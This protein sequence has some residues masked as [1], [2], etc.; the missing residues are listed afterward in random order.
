MI[1]KLQMSK[2]EFAVQ[3]WGLRGNLPVP[4]NETL[5][6]GGNTNCVTVTIANQHLFIFDAGSGI[7][8]LAEYLTENQSNNITASIF[9]SHPH[10]DHINALPHFDPFYAKGNR[11]TIYGA[12]DDDTS[13]EKLMFGQMDNPHYP[14]TMKEMS[15]ELHFQRLQEETLN[16][17]DIQ[18]QT[19]RLNHPGYCLGYR[20]VYENKIF[21]YVTDNELPLKGTELYDQSFVDKLQRFVNNAD[22]LIIDS[23]YTDEEY[24]TKVGWGHS[25]LSQVVGLA[26]DAKVKQ[27]SLFHHCP[28]QKDHEIDLKIQ[29]AKSLLKAY[30]STTE[31]LAPCEGDI[32][33]L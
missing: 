27:L 30:Q 15:A 2:N 9:I 17:D 7:K 19:M 32:L 20:V 22:I 28:I 29:T 24:Q 10:W 8:K 5:R 13:L 14:I 33:K 1:G 21:C 18:I 3:F 25:C 6:Y 12:C 11:F 16:I 26:H 23:T 31:C 4:G